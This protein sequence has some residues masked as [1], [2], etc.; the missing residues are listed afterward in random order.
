MI[1]STPLTSWCDYWIVNVSSYRF[2]K[3]LYYKSMA[4]TRSS[5]PLQYWAPKVEGSQVFH[6]LP[7]KSYKE[8]KK[9]DDLFSQKAWKLWPKVVDTWNHCIVMQFREECK[10]NVENRYSVVMLL[11]IHWLVSGIVSLF[12]MLTS[13]ATLFYSL[14]KCVI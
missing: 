12:H 5:V 1:T 11:I 14:I 13:F 10:N 2:C 9:K 4:A 3:L 8:K 6:I 7:R